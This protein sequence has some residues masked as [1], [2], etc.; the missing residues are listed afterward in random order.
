MAVPA[1]WDHPTPPSRAARSGCD[2]QREVSVLVAPLASRTV[3]VMTVDPVRLDAGVTFTVRLAPVPE[4]TMLAFG[5]SVVFDDA[6]DTRSEETAP[7]MSPTTTVNEIALFFLVLWF[8]VSEMVGASFTGA[9]T[10]A[11]AERSHILGSPL[12]HTV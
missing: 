2:R 4:T 3:S 7:S 11:T 6:P 10:S 9:T 1:A 12:S 8:D 5:T